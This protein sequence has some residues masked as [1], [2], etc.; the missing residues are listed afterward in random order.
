MNKAQEAIIEFF[1]EVMLSV[2]G[3]R[4]RTNN[5]NELMAMIEENIEADKNNMLCKY[6]DEE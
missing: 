4:E 5:I 1:E 6:S 3:S 2:R